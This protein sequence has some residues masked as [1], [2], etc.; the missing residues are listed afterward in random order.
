[1]CASAWA[2]SNRALSRLSAVTSVNAGREARHRGHRQ[3]DQLAAV[4]VIQAEHGAFDDAAGRQGDSGRILV[5]AEFVAA[6]V[7]HHPLP[8]AQ[9]V[10]DAF[11]AVQRQQAHRRAVGV[12]D[13]QIVVLHDHAAIDQLDQL[14]ET[15][16]GFL[17]IA[18]V[19]G[20]GDDAALALVDEAGRMHLDRKAGAVAAFVGDLD[21]VALAAVERFPH[22]DQVIARQFRIEDM[23]RLAE[24]L[25]ADAP[26]F[27]GA[28]AIDL[29]HRA[30]FVEHGDQVGNR[31]EG[32]A[33][34][35][36]VI[37][38]GGLV[39]AAATAQG[40]GG[41][42]E[43]AAQALVEGGVVQGAFER[44][45][46]VRHRGLRRW[47]RSVSGRAG[48]H[49]ARALPTLLPVSRPSRPANQRPVSASAS[50]STPVSMPSPCSM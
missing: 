29:D 43:H 17:A 15:Q 44:R 47:K 32:G 5:P 6:L 3:P 50:R 8:G 40:L 20:D 35:A 37:G 25:V 4:A 9:F 26:V 46:R 36:G 11:A 2:R 12:D 18:E 13:A 45:Q 42:A 22:R 7:D 27:L 38:P 19:A 21:D 33:V 48:L 31:I 39:S 30:L 1:M 34:Q 14:A 23:D 49:A 24:D 16:L 10:G 28:V 41:I